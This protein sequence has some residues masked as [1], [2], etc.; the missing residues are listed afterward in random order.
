VHLCSKEFGNRLADTGAATSD[1]SDLIIQHETQSAAG[2]SFRV[3]HNLGLGFEPS[4]NRKA[5]GKIFSPAA[6]RNQPGEESRPL[7][8]VL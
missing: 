1:D 7:S 8:A 4:G 6:S 2:G 3:S 5:C